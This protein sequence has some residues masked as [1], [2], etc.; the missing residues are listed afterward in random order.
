MLPVIDEVRNSLDRNYIER[1]CRKYCL[2]TTDISFKFRIIDD[3]THVEEYEEYSDDKATNVDSELM[4]VLSTVPEKGILTIEVPA[5]HHIATDWNNTD[6]IH[7]Y[8]PEEFKSRITNVYDKESTSV[9]HVL[10][11]FREGSSIEKTTE[12]QRPISELLSKPNRDK[13]IERLFHQLRKVWKAPEELSLP[14]TANPKKRCAMLVE[15]ISKLYNIDT[16]KK[17]CYKLVKRKHTNDETSLVK[18]PCAFEIIAIPFKDPYGPDQIWTNPKGQ[19]FIGAINYSIS[20]QNNIFEC[21]YPDR[22]GRFGYY[23]PP[24]DITGLLRQ[25][26]FHNEGRAKNKLPCIIPDNSKKGSTRLR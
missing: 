19:E 5:I 3:I 6:S 11:T 16:T 1:F 2:L 21:E 24:K 4:T 22:G 26:G 10:R 20:P 9:Y 23:Y 13:I 8:K 25:Y 7:S 18:Y 12:N 17:A 14:Y 15:R